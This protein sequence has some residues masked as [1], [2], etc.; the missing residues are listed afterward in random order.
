MNNVYI[1]SLY[2]HKYIIDNNITIITDTEYNNYY[3]YNVIINYKTY[4]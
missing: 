1:L 4:I 2:T 3:N